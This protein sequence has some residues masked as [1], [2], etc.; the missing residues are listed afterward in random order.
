MQ[1]IHKIQGELRRNKLSAVLISKPENVFYLCGFK[2][3]FG[4]LLITPRSASLVTDFRYFRVARKQIPKGIVLIDIKKGIKKIL[5]RFKRLGIEDEHIKYSR[6]LDYKKKLKGVRIKPIS[7]L[8]ERMRQVKSAE[9][10][11]IMRKAVKIMCKA[12]EKFTKGIRVGQSEDEMEWNLLSICRVLGAD[13]F[14]FD[15]IISFG[16]N[17][18]DVHHQKEEN[19]LRRG[20]KIMIDFG[21]RYRGYCTDMTRIIYTSPPDLR[22][23]KI[24]STVLEANQAAIASIEVGRKLSEIDKAA[25]DVIE[26]AGYSDKFGHATGH[27]IGLEVHED[28]RV[29]S[30]SDAVV[31]P[32][33]VFTVEPGIYIDR[34]GG[35]RIEDMVYVNFKGE[36]EVLTKE[37]SQQI[38]V[39]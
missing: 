34:V 30:K 20:E 3:T 11:R 13:G 2:G 29:S 9:E 19:R 14:S 35:V 32:G 18:A 16:K 25:R 36:V 1:K 24:Y 12:F 17:T 15:P 6:V 28:P 26:N 21:I 4:L 10:I 7:G 33:M 39:I 8:V 23:Q 22:E 5:G 27:G 31:D 38:V 37:I